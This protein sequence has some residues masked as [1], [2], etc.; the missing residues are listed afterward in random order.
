MSKNTQRLDEDHVLSS[1]YGMTL[2][3]LHEMR[4]K[5]S[6]DPI[7]HLISRVIEFKE[8]QDNGAK[9]RRA[10]RKRTPRVGR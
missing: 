4:K 6:N 2:A 1:L 7:K 9:P 3:E 10:T 8:S 5:K